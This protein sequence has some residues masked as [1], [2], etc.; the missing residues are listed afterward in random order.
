[1]DKA[2]LVRKAGKINQKTE[3]KV[4]AVLAEMFT[5]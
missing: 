5:R 3:E 4:L 2:R 1:V